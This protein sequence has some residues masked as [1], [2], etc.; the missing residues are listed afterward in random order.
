MIKI[1]NLGILEPNNLGK[2]LKNIKILCSLQGQEYQ[3]QVGFPLLEAIKDSELN[4]KKING[5]FPTVNTSQLILSSASA[6][7]LEMDLRFFLIKKEQ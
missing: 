6:Q 4:K 5:N 2:N 3:W 7:N 1:L